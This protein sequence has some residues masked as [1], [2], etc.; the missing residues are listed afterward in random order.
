MPSYVFS[1][2][3]WRNQQRINAL[4]EKR[5]STSQP[6]AEKFKGWSTIGTTSAAIA[7]GES[8]EV[9]LAN[10]NELEQG[11]E[12]L[13]V[14]N[15]TGRELAA[16]TQVECHYFAVRGADGFFAAR[17]TEV[18]EGDGTGATR[19]ASASDAGSGVGATA[20]VP[21]TPNTCAVDQPLPIPFT[22]ETPRTGSGE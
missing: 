2:Q 21:R 5:L 11:E 17:P 10:G 15:L 8:G 18:T 16:D 1:E 14:R 4:V 3:G 12:T 7:A 6:P 20:V 19:S 9:K 22:P 13:T